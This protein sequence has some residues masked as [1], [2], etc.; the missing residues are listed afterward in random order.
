MIF[1]IIYAIFLLTQG[2]IAYRFIRMN[3]ML[4]L[5][6]VL[7][8]NA[9]FALYV[10]AEAIFQINVPH[11]LRILVICILFVQN[12]FGYFK[13]RFTYSKVF[14]R[15]LHIWGTIG[16]TLFLYSILI[17]LVEPFIY[18]KVL[19]AVFVFTLG[20]SIGTLFE[21]FEFSGDQ[22]MHEP[23]KMQKGLKDTNVDLI[24]DVFGSL[25]AAI[26]AYLFI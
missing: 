16:F 22:S 24:C 11:L 20:I 17:L 7:V 21:I 3:N 6:S 25:I 4:Y 1:W 15:H 5:K 18:P 10:I 19:E 13:D 23:V 14:D 26:A 2:F 12:Y 8:S 9:L